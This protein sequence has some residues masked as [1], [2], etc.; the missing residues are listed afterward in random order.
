MLVKIC[1]RLYV[2]PKE[3]QSL[4]DET[5]YS[6]PQNKPTTRIT[7]KTDTSISVPLFMDDVVKLLEIV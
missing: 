6:G 4:T 7:F 2:N 3:V 5:R 1:D